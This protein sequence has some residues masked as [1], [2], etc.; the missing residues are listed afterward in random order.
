VAKPLSACWRIRKK[1]YLVVVVVFV[2]CWD[3]VEGIQGACPKNFLGGAGPQNLLTMVIIL[4][5]SAPSPL[6]PLI[7]IKM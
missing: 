1:K 3:E 4:P 7:N 2:V 5:P 6:P